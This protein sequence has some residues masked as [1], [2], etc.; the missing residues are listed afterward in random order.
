MDIFNGKSEEGMTYI[1]LIIIPAVIGIVAVLSSFSADGEVNTN[2]VVAMLIC[3]AI[4]LY[5]ILQ[6]VMHEA[7]RKKREPFSFNLKKELDAA[8]PSENPEEKQKKKFFS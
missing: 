8:D 6:Y 4:S 3:F 1:F 5:F 7:E 2:M